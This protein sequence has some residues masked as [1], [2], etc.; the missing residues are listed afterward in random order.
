MN[1]P[2]PAHILHDVWPELLDLR[3][4]LRSRVRL[5][6]HVY[7][8][9]VCYIY[10]DSGSDNFYRFS[11]E[12]YS[13]I[14]LL[15]GKTTLGE[16]IASRPE[17]WQERFP[18]E[19][20]TEILL[21]LHSVD[22]I[23]SNLPPQVEARLQQEKQETEPAGKPLV[24]LHLLFFRIPLLDPEPFLEKYKRISDLFFKRSFLYLFVALLL[25]AAIQLVVH[26]QP[27]TQNIVDS[28]FTRNNLFLLWIIYPVVKTIHELAH[29]F[30][31]KKWGGEVHELGIMFLLLMPVPY[32][33]ASAATVFPD[34]WQRIAVSGAG[35]IAELTLAALAL[36]LWPSV[37]ASLL[38]TICYNV[39]LIAGFSTLLFNGNPLV[40]FDGYY[41]LSDIIEIPNLGPRS[42]A[43]LWYLF[44]RYVLAITEV[45]PAQMSAG[46]RK[47]FI[48]YGVASFCYRVFLYTSIF[49]IL[50]KFF[51]V[52]GIVFGLL[53][54]FQ[55]FIAPLVRRMRRLLTHPGYEPYRTRIRAAAALMIGGPAFL[56]LAIPMPYSTEVEGVLW[57]PDD[58]IVRMQTTGFIETVHVS[59]YAPV[60]PGTVLIEGVDPE[61]TAAIDLLGSQIIEHRLK[62]SAAFALDPLESKIIEER[63]QDLEKR[64][65][66]KL[67][68]QAQLTIRSG[69]EGRFVVPGSDTIVG[70][71]RRQGDILG[72][73][74]QPVNRVKV[75]V[76]QQQIDTIGANTTGVELVVVNRPDKIYRASIMTKSPQ[77][78]EYLPHKAL[79]TE[80][81]GAILV[82]P[83]DDT[84]LRMLEDMFLLDVQIDSP[85]ENTFIGSRVFV[86]FR[87]GNEP[88]FFRYVKTI[89]QLFL[90]LLHP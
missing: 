12:V 43:Y 82:D 57:P 72:Y 66:D 64:F 31:I 49:L 33:N 9:E 78:T 58:A 81:G 70:N 27:F 75:L 5:T 44:E 22:A 90:N 42:Q 80:G 13:F 52:A 1:N 15:D 60:A 3:I 56:L 7:R 6:R 23:A 59:P 53:S 37:E 39:I 71:Y 46:E 32:V 48:F 54:L 35:I 11:P 41:I 25:L 69:A 28:L 67:E 10:S 20:I 45:K 36:L 62:S 88:L 16:I 73:I 2:A 24:G 65:Q 50:V 14:A 61:L 30:A 26:W 79:G 86:Q 19:K 89:Q 83:S 47:W 21:Q 63:L 77:A 76:S 4:R 51:A 40:R 85:L 17:E 29:S 87:H 74:L 38:R 68:E 55:L 34:K 84:G 8:G 18:P